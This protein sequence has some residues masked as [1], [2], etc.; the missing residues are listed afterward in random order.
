[1][2]QLG[3]RSHSPL[4]AARPARLPHLAPGRG[5]RVLLR[6]RCGPSV[7]ARRSSAG[8][9]AVRDSWPGC[10]RGVEP[11]GCG[12]RAAAPPSPRRASALP[13]P[14]LPR[15]RGCQPRAPRPAPALP[16]PPARGAHWAKGPGCLRLPLAGSRSLPYAPSPPCHTCTCCVPTSSSAPINFYFDSNCGGGRG[17][18]DPQGRRAAVRTRRGGRN[19]GPGRATLSLGLLVFS[20][21]FLFFS[22]PPPGFKG[23][24]PAEARGQ[25]S[26]V[27]P[28]S[29]RPL[30][31]G[32]TLP[33]PEHRLQAA[34]Y[35]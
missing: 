4:R 27:S 12:G 14:R 16:A 26:A 7:P 24:A 17:A 22:L 5:P 32:R 19:G 20:L 8:R 35:F 29:R 10:A 34:G 30:R 25:A 13:A 15:L 33:H 11:S 3:T 23:T 2:P 28:V 18:Q 6:R 9:R 31:P 21:S 1:M